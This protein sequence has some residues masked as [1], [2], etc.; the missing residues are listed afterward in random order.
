MGVFI[1]LGPSKTSSIRKNTRLQPASSLHHHSIDPLYYETSQRSLCA[2]GS[3]HTERLRN[4]S[5][6]FMI[7][8]VN[9]ILDLFWNPFVSDVSFAIAI[10][11]CLILY[12]GRKVEKFSSK[13]V[14]RHHLLLKV[15]LHWANANFFLWFWSFNLNK[16]LWAGSSV[17]VVS[18]GCSM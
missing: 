17:L 2:I 18:S 12:R 10:E 7:I 11:R 9:I 4:I 3:I 8:G 13:Q 15:H 5:F 6:M 1:T 14:L 16:T